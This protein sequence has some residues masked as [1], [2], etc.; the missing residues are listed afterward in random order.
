MAIFDCWMHNTKP[1][2]ALLLI[3]K[4][5]WIRGDVWLT[6]VYISIPECTTCCIFRKSVV[7]SL[8]AAASLWLR[9]E[10]AIEAELSGCF[11]VTLNAQKAIKPP[12]SP[13]PG[14]APGK[15]NACHEEMTCQV[16]VNGNA[17]LCG[18]PLTLVCV[19]VREKHTNIRHVRPSY[20]KG[21]KAGLWDPHDMELI[22]GP[23]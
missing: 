7:M 2:C 3:T 10:T 9:T 13:R 18:L 5:L 19:C 4:R 21:M 1:L 12:P 16:R 17:A 11:G 15:S 20:G 22:I 8:I 6:D 14:S 23:W